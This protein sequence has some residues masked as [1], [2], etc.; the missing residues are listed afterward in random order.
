MLLLLSGAHHPFCTSCH[1]CPDFQTSCSVSL[2]QLCF[3]ILSLPSAIHLNKALA[4]ARFN[5]GSGLETQGL[6]QG[7]TDCTL[8]LVSRMFYLQAI[9]ST[10]CFTFLPMSCAMQAPSLQSLATKQLQET[11]QKPLRKKREAHFGLQG[12]L[13]IQNMLYLISISLHLDQFPS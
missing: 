11:D 10:N 13:L 4:K 6:L 3:P 2:W 12:I 9:S 8:L 1:P 5:A 7:D